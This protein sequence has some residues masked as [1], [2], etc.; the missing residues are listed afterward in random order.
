MSDLQSTGQN[1]RFHLVRKTTLC[2]VFLIVFLIVSISGWL[3][4]YSHTPGPTGPPDVV[5]SIP[6]GTSVEKINKILAEAGVINGDIRFSY[7]ARLK[8]MASKLRAGEFALK[9]GKLPIEIMHDLSKAVPLQHSVTIAEGLRATEI[10]KIFA[11][12]NWCAE[13]EFLELI[14]DLQFITSLGFEKLTSLEGYLYPDTYSL[15]RIPELSAQDIIKMMVHRF[16]E[17]WSK[18]DGEDD[19]IHETVILASIV[20]KETAAPFERGL[21]AS[22]FHQRLARGMRLQS[23]PTVIYGLNNF[24]GNL[25][26]K[27]LRTTTPYNTYVISGLPVGPICNPGKAAL[28]AVLHPSDE[29]YLYFVSKNDGTHH[30]SKNLQEHNRAVYKYQKRKVKKAN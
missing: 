12:G 1:T 23:D 7:L 29:H 5:V 19:R 6:K 4:I 14:N 22:V 3:W 28:A 20:E 30:F 26:R 18:L 25:T 8:G 24:S 15:T 11:D 13:Q 2:L 21:I 16:Y 9:T 17:I 27:D 10:A